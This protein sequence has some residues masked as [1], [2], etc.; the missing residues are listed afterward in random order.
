MN[1]SP[2]TPTA[3]T[4]CRRSAPRRG[5]RSKPQVRFIPRDIE[6]AASPY[7]NA[8]RVIVTYGMGITQHSRGTENVQQIAN[9]L[10]LRGNIGKPG[11]GI[12]RCAVT[13]T[14]RAIARS[15]LPKNPTRTCSTASNR[16][17]FTPPRA[18]HGTMRWMRS[19]RSVM[20]L[21]GADLPWRQSGRCD[22]RPRGVCR[23]CASSIWPSISQP[24]STARI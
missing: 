6:A 2:S 17:G 10:L 12:C 21:Q 9:L 14:C 3:S 18:H 4:R 23:A 1:S 22:V 24:S 13:P 8:K 15:A 7:A 16:F 11:A 20:A 19:R 5:K